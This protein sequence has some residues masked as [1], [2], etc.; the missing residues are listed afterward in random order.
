MKKFKI[1]TLLLLGTLLYGCSDDNVPADA[2]ENF[3]TS[4]TL[5]KDGESYSATISGNEIVMSVPYIVDLDNAAADIS[6]TPSA[7]ILPN[8]NTFTQWDSEQIFRVTSYNGDTNEYVYKVIK[9]EIESEGDV[10][11]KDQQAVDA[12]S[13]TNITVVKG[14]LVIGDNADNATPVNN[15]MALSAIKEV[16]GKIVILNNYAGGDLEGLNMTSAGGL[17]IGTENSMSADSKL[18]RC[19]IESLLS[20]DGD[21]EIYDGGIQFVEFDNLTKINGNCL[22]K[23]ASLTTIQCPCLAEVAKQLIVDGASKSELTT[24]E[25]P[26]LEKVGDTLRVTGVDKL[27]AL[28]FPELRESGTIDF[29]HIGAELET[30]SLPNLS[31]VN[32]DLTLVSEYGGT[33][34]QTGNLKLEKIDGLNNLVQVK[35]CIRIE[36]LSGLNELPNFSN[37]T[38]LGSFYMRYMDKLVRTGILNLSNAHFETFNGVT[39]YILIG[40]QGSAPLLKEIKTQENLSGVDLTITVTNDDE[41]QILPSLNTKS[42][43]SVE[44]FCNGNDNHEWRGLEAVEKNLSVTTMRAKSFSL[45]GLKSVGGF[46]VFNVP[47]SRSL[48]LPQLESVGGQLYLR[49][50]AL[51][52][53]DFKKLQTVGLAENPQYQEEGNIKGTES[54]YG[55][56]HIINGAVEFPSLTK[57]GNGISASGV[58]FLKFPVLTSIDGT[59]TLYNCPRPTTLELS[60]LKQLK[61]VYF[62]N[63]KISDFSVFAPMIADGQI[64]KE[65]WSVTDCAYNPT[66]EDMKAGRYKPAE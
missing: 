55:V 10:V 37:I 18:Y 39:P 52:K 61:G 6:Y 56:L 4:L 26:K 38:V 64:T 65:K 32:G 50:S 20:I 35:G 11:L 12:F 57:I 34:I 45:S 27:A 51:T 8:P 31:I 13:D 60:V 28:K 19:R 3:I 23:I 63:T 17:Q 44:I 43:G 5:T 53:F 49:S 47:M 30:L 46:A 58:T 48:A 1:A 41:G 24:L 36:W 22:L 7:T 15:L 59:F 40:R 33:Y 29:S 25:F 54:T 66:Y 21:V 62:K 2:D 42:A 9:T 16:K 14:N